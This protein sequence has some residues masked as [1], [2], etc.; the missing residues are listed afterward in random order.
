MPNIH[1]FVDAKTRE[2]LIPQITLVMCNL[3]LQ[4]DA[5]ITWHGPWSVP[6]SCDGKRTPMPCIAVASTN[7]EEALSIVTELKEIDFSI[8]CEV[9]P[10]IHSFIPADKMRSE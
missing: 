10:Q 9:W 8:D 3:R 5:V 1:L 6:I 4:K 2:A 7:I